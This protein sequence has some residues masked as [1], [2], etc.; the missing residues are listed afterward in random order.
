MHDRSFLGFLTYSNQK[1][2]APFR[3]IKL[4]NQTPSLVRIFDKRMKLVVNYYFSK[5]EE[6]SNF[7]KANS[8]ESENA[9][10]IVLTASPPED[11]IEL[12]S[13]YNRECLSPISNMDFQFWA[14]GVAWGSKGKIFN[15]E[16]YAT[17]QLFFHVFIS[18]FI[19]LIY[20]YFVASAPKSC[21]V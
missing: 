4:S 11:R 2:S 12:Q 17:F 15:V 21:T 1:E 13:R 19:F 6:G 18:E 10:E 3:S 5:N 9:I 14:I 8:L 20:F 7:S 16:L